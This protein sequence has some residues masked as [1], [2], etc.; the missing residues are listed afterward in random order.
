MD[1]RV[2]PADSVDLVGNCPR[3]DRAA[4]ITRD[5]PDG[6]RGQI[7]H[8][9]G[10]LGGAS[11]QNNFV[12]FGHEGACRRPAESVGGAGDEDATSDERVRHEP[13]IARIICKNRVYLI[14]FEA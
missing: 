1:H 12:T 6:P 7:R 3:F 2:H 11:V 8:S 9:G 13:I 10:S 5:D 14:H 4:Q